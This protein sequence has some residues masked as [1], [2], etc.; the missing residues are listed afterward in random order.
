M[1]AYTVCR[2]NVYIDTS[3]IYMK[4]G[5]TKTSFYF[6]YLNKIGLIETLNPYD[7]S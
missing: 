6:E 2:L 3:A 5:V 1:I 4:N 7:V